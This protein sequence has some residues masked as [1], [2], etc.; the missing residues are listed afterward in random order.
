M[1]VRILLVDD[2]QILRD[3]LRALI[4]CQKDLRIVG[5]AD[6][7]L[8]AVRLAQELVPD[9]IIMDI[10]MHDLNG[11]DATR[12]IL[13]KQPAVKVVALSMRSDRRMVE[14]MLRA[15]ASG[16]L[17]KESAFKELA[18]AIRTVMQGGRYLSP[19]IGKMMG[20]AENRQ[21]AQGPAANNT[22]FT[23]LSE[24]EREVLQL[25]A[26]GRTTKEIAD[27]LFL[28]AKTVESHRL[29]IMEKLRLFSVADLTKYAVREGL[30]TL[31]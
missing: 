25:L 5:E 28:S 7:G 3:G 16:Y 24:R 18:V 19:A 8:A 31:E 4:E 6:G 22:A 29:R 17:L 20:V 14:E 9:L 11:I 30:T 2:H 26:E 15:G 1:S 13:S 27:K 10:T 21:G 23:A 12:Q